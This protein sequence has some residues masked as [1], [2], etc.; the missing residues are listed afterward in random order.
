MPGNDLT[1]NL[2]VGDYWHSVH[3]LIIKS[4]IQKISLADRAIFPCCR[5][6]FLTLADEQITLKNRHL[7]HSVNKN[8]QKNHSR[9]FPGEILYA[10]EITAHTVNHR[11]GLIK[12][13]PDREES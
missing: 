6:V 4:A 13:T 9:G 3:P 1:N 12:S 2:L 10:P 5:K 7:Q 11:Q 8:K